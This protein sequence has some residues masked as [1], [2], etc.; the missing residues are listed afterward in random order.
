MWFKYE[1][2]AMEY[3]FKLPLR[4][5]GVEVMTYVA[6]KLGYIKL[7]TGHLDLAIELGKGWQSK[8]GHANLRIPRKTLAFFSSQALEPRRCGR[9]SRILTNNIGSSAGLVNLSS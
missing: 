7:I 8:R 9:C 2:M 5:E 6:D 4:G 3:I 1:V